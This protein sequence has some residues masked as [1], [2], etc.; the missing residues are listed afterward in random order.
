MIH[1]VWPYL[2]VM[3]LVAGLFPALERYTGWRV[4][5]VLPPI[6]LTYLVVTACACWRCSPP[7]R[8]ACL[9]PS[10]PPS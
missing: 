3:L 7:P 9:S 5:N 8:C 1:T 10:S 6:V 4:F 2:A